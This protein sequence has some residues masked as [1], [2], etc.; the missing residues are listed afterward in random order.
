[1]DI[2]R[3]KFNLGRKVIYHDTEYVL[4][5]CIIRASEQ[6]YFY[7]AELKDLSALHSVI[8]ARLSEVEEVTH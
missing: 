5:A 8:V 7:Q 3:V 1:M 2:S 4:S 6:G